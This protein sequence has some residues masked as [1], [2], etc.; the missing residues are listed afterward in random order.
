[1][2]ARSLA[3]PSGNAI[4]HCDARTTWFSPKQR[5]V[6]AGYSQLSVDRVVASR[7][8]DTVFSSSGSFAIPRADKRA[9]TR[10]RLKDLKSNDVEWRPVN[11]AKE[12][13]PDLHRGF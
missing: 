12:L 9:V 13:K 4:V 5:D 2:V 1:M 11:M 3:N 8:A 6:G 7:C 10:G